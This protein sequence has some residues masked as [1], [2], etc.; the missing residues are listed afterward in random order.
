VNRQGNVLLEL[1]ASNGYGGES[2]MSLLDL[3]GMAPEREDTD[4]CGA[5]LGS[6]LS[7]LLCDSIASLTLCL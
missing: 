4:R 2:I 7:V 3:Q 1:I 6:H 5:D